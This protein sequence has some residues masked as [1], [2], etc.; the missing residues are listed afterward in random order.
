MSGRREAVGALYRC[1]RAEKAAREQREWADLLTVRSATEAERLAG[2]IDAALAAGAEAA[3]VVN[4]LVQQ[5]GGDCRRVEGAWRLQVA[6]V[7]A[8][9]AEGKTGLLRAW[10]LEAR[11]EARK[12]EGLT[13]KQGKRRRKLKG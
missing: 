4:A 10:L 6:G 7:S 3:L 8:A 5:H 9:S 1:A 12:P 11:Q 2:W 13:G